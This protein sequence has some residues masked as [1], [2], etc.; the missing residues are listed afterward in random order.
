MARRF[1]RSHSEKM[2]FGVCG[3]LAEYFQ[4]D[5]VLV[6]LAFVLLAVSGGVGLIAYVILAVIT[7]RAGTA[8]TPGETVRENIQE[9]RTTAEEMA[10]EIQSGFGKERGKGEKAE[11]DE[12]KGYRQRNAYL[13]GLILIVA[14]LLFLLGNFGLFTWFEWRLFWPVILIAIGL[15]IIGSRRG[16]SEKP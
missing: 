16:R 1:Y 15:L 2:V 6:R 13:G 14:G 3:G 12:V 9:I 11:E 5:V 7:P 8:A 4:V 10:S